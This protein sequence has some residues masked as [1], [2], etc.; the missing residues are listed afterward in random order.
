MFVLVI[1]TAAVGKISSSD[2][3]PNS[4]VQS[5]LANGAVA[6]QTTI[7]NALISSVNMDESEK[8]N[9]DPLQSLSPIRTKS[10]SG[11]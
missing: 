7:L 11:Q 8:G 9:L 6:N 1:I 3:L 4:V 5:F 2:V 10:A